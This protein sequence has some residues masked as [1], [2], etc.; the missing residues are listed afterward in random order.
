MLCD[1]DMLSRLLKDVWEDAIASFIDYSPY[2]GSSAH[3][4]RPRYSSPVDWSQ[5]EREING[6]II[7]PNRVFCI[8][9]AVEGE[10]HRPRCPIW[11]GHDSGYSLKK[12]RCENCD[13]YFVALLNNLCWVCQYHVD[14]MVKR[15][16]N[17]GKKNV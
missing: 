6:M 11:M 1:S 17:T 5:R 2:I 10:V 13:G 8:C 16:S 3:W 4:I 14:A 15:L 12:E 7:K 9:G